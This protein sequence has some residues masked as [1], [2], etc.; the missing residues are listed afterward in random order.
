[1]PTFT[2]GQHPCGAI[3]SEANFHRSRDVVTVAS[4]QGKLPPGT[5]LAKAADATT[6]TQVTADT[7]ATASAV[8]LYPVD[9]TSTDAKAT[10][11][12]RDAELRS[13][14]LIYGSD[15]STDALKAS[16][17]T[18]LATNGLIVR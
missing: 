15:V 2:E 3:L 10:A 12:V 1:M 16:V 7:V 17:A 4:G 14:N 11:A 18:A 9:A 13:G 6:Y 5:V 8:L